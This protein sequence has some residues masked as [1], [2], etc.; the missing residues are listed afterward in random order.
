[1]GFI[2]FSLFSKKTKFELVGS[3]CIAVSSLLI[4][5]ISADGTAILSAPFLY[6]SSEHT[7]S[8]FYGNCRFGAGTIVY[9]IATML[10]STFGIINS[11]VKMQTKPVPP[12]MTVS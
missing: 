3:I 11:A 10:A 5:S 9:A 6:G 4:F 1:M 12:S 8:A 2:V 7:F